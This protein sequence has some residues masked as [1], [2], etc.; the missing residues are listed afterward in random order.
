MD[1]KVVSGDPPGVHERLGLVR[2]HFDAQPPHPIN[3]RIG[4]AGQRSG[5]VLLVDRSAILG[6]PGRVARPNQVP[7]RGMDQPHVLQ[8]DDTG[9]ICSK[10]PRLQDRDQHLRGLN[11]A[12]VG[13]A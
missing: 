5:L 9:A 12:A 4:E 7:H 2:V 6:P 10:R 8:G 3:H 1:A 13:I 11:H